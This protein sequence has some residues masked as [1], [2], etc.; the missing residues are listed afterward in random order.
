MALADAGFTV[1]AVCLGD[2]P[3]SKTTVMN[4]IYPYRAL[5]P[6]ESIAEAVVNSKPDLLLPC[7]DLASEH[8]QELYEREYSRK[9]QATG[10]CALVERSMG[11][12][13]AH[14]ILRQRAE[15]MELA[16]QEGVRVPRTRAIEQPADLRAWTS[17]EGF[18][19]VFK[20]NGTTGGDGVRV[21][22]SQE[23]AD[24][25]YRALHAPPLLARAIKRAVLGEDRTLV[26]AWLRRQRPGVSAQSFVPGHE[27]TTLVACW[28]GKVLAALHFEVLQKRSASGPATVLRWIDNADMKMAA[29]KLVARLGL[30]GLQ[31]FD[32]MLDTNTGNAYL[33]EINPRATQVGH[34]TLGAGR[35]LPAA[36]FAAVTGKPLQPAPAITDKDTI[37]IF[38]S[39]WVRDPNSLYL[40]QGYHDVPWSQPALL[41]DTIEK[42]NAKRAWN[43]RERF[44][45]F[46]APARSNRA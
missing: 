41:L 45:E 32:F 4:R 10:L 20:A 7:D 31:G 23:E 46:F 19:T 27:S 44:S 36:L 9:N 6:L 40:T 35:D 3:L 13:T 33:I 43:P 29:E 21:V 12:A 34:L 38:P 8:L 15:F 1:D 28:E 30:S 17:T 37:A 18:P 14:P 11:P 26:R 42:R 39:E 5:S 25:A 2:H 16:R 24:A 22:R